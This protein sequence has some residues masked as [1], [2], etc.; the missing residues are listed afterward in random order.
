M[1]FAKIVN[2]LQYGM[3]LQEDVKTEAVNLHYTGIKI[4]TCVIHAK[5][6]HIICKTQKG[7]KDVQLINLFGM[8]NIA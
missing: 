4:K 3:L 1:V 6:E 7:A 8:A 5:T 2:T